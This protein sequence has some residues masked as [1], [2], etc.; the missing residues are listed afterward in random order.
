MER[1]QKSH[2]REYGFGI[3]LLI[4]LYL[5]ETNN[6]LLFHTLAEL[7]SI[8][9]A[10]SVFLLAWNCRCFTNDGYLL[11]LG[12]GYLFIGGLDLLH[13]FTYKGM[14]IF[15]GDTANIS[16]QLWVS[17]RYIESFTL[18]A[19]PVI[20]MSKYRIP[21]E[22]FFILYLTIFIVDVL[23]IFWLNIFP[24]CFIEGEGLT[25]FKITSEFIICSI[26]SSALF[27]MYKKQAYFN[28]QM[29]SWLRLSI[30]FAIAGELFFTLY[31]D[32]YGI[33][34]FLGHYCKLLSYYFI[35][36]AII[37]TTLFQPFD[38]LFRGLNREIERG[39]A[40]EAE[41]RKSEHR[42]KESQEVAKIGS[43]EFNFLT[44]KM[45]WSE[46][47]FRLFERD[48]AQGEPSQAEF[49]QYF[50][51]ESSDMLV[52]C[53]KRALKQKTDCCQDFQIYLP[54]GKTV[55]H[56]TVIKPIEN[57]QG[58][59]VKL[60][61]IIQ[62]VTERK[63]D[64]MELRQIEE[65]LYKSEERFELAMQGASDGLWDW[66]L[67]TNAVYYSPRWKAMLGYAEHEISAHL[68]EWKRLVHPEDEGL[69]LK[70]VK[71][72]LDKKIPFFRI[73][74]RMQHKAGHYIWI[75]G[76]AIGVWD[77]QGKPIRM[78]GTHVDITE[79]KQVELALYESKQALEQANAQ[80]NQFKT[81]LDMTLDAVFM[82]DPKR[83]KFSYIN[84]GFVNLLG[85]TQQ[86]LLTISLLDLETEAFSEGGFSLSHGSFLPVQRYETEYRHKNS[87]FIPVEVFLQYIPITEKE[88]CFVGIVRDIT[89]RKQAEAELR[90][91]KEE[92]ERAQQVAE[93]ANQA[94]SNFLANMSH[95]L[96]TPLNGILGYTQILKRDVTLTVD[97]QKGID[98]IHRS[99]EYLLTLIND[100]LDLSKV[101][102]QH[103]ELHPSVFDFSKFLQGIVELFQMR[104][105][106]KGISF[107]YES[108]PQLPKMIEADET[109]LRQILL[110]LL[111]NAVKFTPEGC[112][113]LQIQSQGEKVCF[114]IEDTGIGIDSDML[115]TIFLPFEQVGDVNYKAQGTGLGLAISK[116]LVILMG[117]KLQV[118]SQLGQGTRFWFEIDLPE[119]ATSTTIS[120]DSET[121]ADNIIGF[122]GNP[123]KILIADDQPENCSVLNELFTSLGFLTAEVYDGAQAVAKVEQWQPDLIF[124][125]LVMP[126]M[127][128]LTATQQIRKELKLDKVI[129]IAISASASNAHQDQSKEMGCDDFIAK[130]WHTTELLQ[131]VQKHLKLEWTYQQVTLEKKRPTVDDIFTKDY[132]L[133]PKQAA[134]LLDLTMRGNIDGIIALLEQL[135]RVDGRLEPLAHLIRQMT[136]PLQKKKICAI[137]QHY[138][139][140]I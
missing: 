55:Y 24:I 83:L 104:T 118:N 50:H 98:I 129:I 52:T 89:E 94:K 51:A 18:L 39:Q 2:Y 13:T 20:V 31:K 63:Q 73:T 75:L 77:K 3:L 139:E 93:I 117:G 101:E 71:A 10:G 25:Y 109:R 35:Y 8:I 5:A 67:E 23:A 17:A 137:A 60:L 56:F 86:E 43:W 132:P 108:S 135:E 36:K 57:E 103:M 72:Y 76:R 105:Q 47:V 136:E 29:L 53:V 54:S 88:S 66:N 46:Q 69:V 28:M 121:W 15:Q 14:N 58:R 61:G 42:L 116:K 68:S 82:L 37:E 4:G 44:Q 40:V 114:R 85:Y 113:K 30:F 11:F 90:Q 134:V 130:P 115:E 91:A 87:T 41:L 22:F 32:L 92:A 74:F 106:Q 112:V 62:D 49:L 126:V 9:I 100:I 48:P 123:R 79:H 59:V 119:I 120:T 138:L 140:K 78:V 6:Y 97:Q 70:I 7:A 21:P 127:D 111:S 26:F 81:T 64:V 84:S 38:S 65:A 27:Y 12:I 1:T 19:I 125:D 80:L 16:I 133:D 102:A 124:M 34:S 95:E 122:E 96:R 107:N 110:N 45:T 128:G 131:C 33:P 99:A